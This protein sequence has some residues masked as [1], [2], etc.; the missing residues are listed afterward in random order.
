MQLLIHK[1]GSHITKD[2][3]WITKQTFGK[4]ILHIHTDGCYCLMAVTV[5]L[6]SITYVRMKI[7]FN[8]FGK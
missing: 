7:K 3:I 1:T 8:Q 6:G 4:N 2:I 5:Q